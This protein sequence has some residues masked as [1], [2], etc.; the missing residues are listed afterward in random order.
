TA[1]PPHDQSDR[2]GHRTVQARPGAPR[3]EEPRPH[4]PGPRTRSMRA[5]RGA[6]AGDQCAQHRSGHATEHE[7]WQ[8]DSLPLSL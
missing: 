6:N 8:Q 2:V 7:S 3:R 5:G 4:I 1:P